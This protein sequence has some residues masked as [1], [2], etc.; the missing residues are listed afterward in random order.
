MIDNLAHP[1][2]YS[3]VVMIGGSFQMEV[4]KGLVHPHQTLLDD[5][6]INTS[7]YVVVKVDMLHENMKNMNLEVPPDDTRL[8]LWDVITRRVQW[9]RIYIDVDLSAAASVL[10]TSQPNTATALIFN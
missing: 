10:T 5:V 8:T 7:A 4:G 3:L 1:I 9:R 2:A 6:Q